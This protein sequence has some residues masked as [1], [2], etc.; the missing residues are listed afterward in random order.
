MDMTAVPRINWDS[1]VLTE[2]WR[3]FKQH[4]QLMFSGPL[5]KKTESEKVSYLLIWVGEAGRDIYNT[6]CDIT[7]DNRNLLETYYTKF[8]AHVTPTSNT[9]FAR[10]KFNN[11]LQKDEP[12]D[13]FVTDLKLLVKNCGY[14]KPDEM[15]RDRI[16]FGIKSRK[17]REKLLQVG[18]DLTLRKAVEIV[19]STEQCQLQLQSMSN[20][21]SP[22]G[23]TESVLAVA[24]RSNLIKN[25]YFCGRDHKK[26]KCPAYGSTCTKCGQ[27][28]H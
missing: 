6:W 24:N 3:K 18:S 8:E 19:H 9:L 28:N 17:T 7:D 12:F 11:R 5:K 4:A 13:N 25:C 2:E 16:V 20:D 10:Y 22:V 1:S 14:E 21:Q 26:N 27:K 15:V 23:N